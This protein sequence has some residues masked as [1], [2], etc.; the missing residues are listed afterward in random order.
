M[1][2][3]VAPLAPAVLN[4]PTGSLAPST[5][6][7]AAGK[8]GKRRPP[9]NTSDLANQIK[10]VKACSKE[11]PWEKQHRGVTAAWL[12]VCDDVNGKT[13]PPNAPQL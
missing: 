11:F 4:T 13:L 9:W 7:V 6:A 2:F 3:P 12:A 5:P 1:P 10:L 8:S